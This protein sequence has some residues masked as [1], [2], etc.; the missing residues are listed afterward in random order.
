MK[1]ELTTTEFARNHAEYLNRVAY[2][3]ESFVITRGKRQIA[4]VRPVQKPVMLHD[5]S[6]ILD[7][8][9]RLSRDD[10]DEFERDIETARRQL[11]AL[12]MDDPWDR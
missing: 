10:L 4:E 8:L 12:P 1:T 3:G 5:L 6:Q 2:R 11:P 9:P 7:S